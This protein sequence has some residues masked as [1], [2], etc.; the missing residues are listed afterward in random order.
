M[1]P[2]SCTV[3]LAAIA[4]IAFSFTIGGCR[5]PPPAASKEAGVPDASA[6]AGVTSTESPAQRVATTLKSH[7]WAGRMGDDVVELAVT[8]GRDTVLN[9]ELVFYQFGRPSFRE[10]VD[11]DIGADQRLHVHGMK[12]RRVTRVTSIDASPDDLFVCLSPDAKTLTN[13]PEDAGDRRSLTAD[14]SAPELSAPLDVAKFERL[15]ET[16]KWAGWLRSGKQKIPLT[17]AVARKGTTLTAT[18]TAGAT[19]WT[20]PVSVGPGGTF[21][22]EPAPNAGV[23]GSTS[24]AFAAD[25]RSDLNVIE[26]DHEFRVTQGF[27]S[28]EGAEPFVLINQKVL[29]PPARRK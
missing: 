16:G 28:Q 24:D 5:K 17:L 18:M 23:R 20:A 21:K 26:G 4:A 8:R 25:I 15:L 7:K 11:V 19:R 27:I 3:R 22:F 13:C 29:P 6:D 10:D 12:V 14:A 9:G 2:H 1:N